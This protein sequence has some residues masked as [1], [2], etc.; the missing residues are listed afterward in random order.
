MID[1]LRNNSFILVLNFFSG[2]IPNPKTLHNFIKLSGF[3]CKMKVYLIRHGESI[4]NAKGIHQ[5]QKNDFPLS[6][7][8]RDQAKSLENFFKD[9]KINTIYS[10]DLKRAKETADIIS[11]S[12]EFATITDKRLR[13]RDFGVMGEKEDIMEEWNDFLKDKIEKGIDPREATPKGGES[14]KD[15]FD[16]VNSFFEDLKKN[17]GKDDVI[18]IVA[19]GGTNKVAMGVVNHFS[20]EEM[21]KT[22]Q[23]HTCINEFIL[24]NGKWKV[25]MINCMDHIEIDQRLIR[26]FEKLRDEPLDVINNRCWEKHSRL[27]KIFNSLGYRTKYKVCSFRWSEQKLPSE[28]INPP[29]EDLDYHLFLEVKVNGLN[30]TVDASNDPSLPDYNAWDGRSNC[31]LSVTPKEFIKENT[32]E[33]IEKKINKE[34]PEKQLNFLKEVNL[35]FENSR[36]NNLIRKGV[37]GK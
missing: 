23:G 25:E 2:H 5:G 11:R 27:K 10:S 21:Y 9:I 29:Y 24:E 14:D 26:E 36:K 22:P 3:L 4:G 18:I 1:F 16:R 31:N 30:L 37:L 6:E 7:R 8:G 15:H 19:H 34:Y 13:E 35:F 17:H 20:L 28:I 12:K 32:E 33:I